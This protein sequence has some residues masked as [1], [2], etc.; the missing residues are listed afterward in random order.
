MTDD[1]H[2]PQIKIIDESTSEIISKSKSRRQFIKSP[3]GLRDNPEFILYGIKTFGADIFQIASQGLRDDHDFVVKAINLSTYVYKYLSKQWREE[4]VGL[5]E[6]K[7]L[8]KLY[9]FLPKRFHD[10]EALLIHTIGY[11][12]RNFQFASVRLKNKYACVMVAIEKHGEVLQY[13]DESFKN[14]KYIVLKAVERGR[15]MLKYASEALRDDRD[16][17]MKAM[18]YDVFN[19]PY[20]SERLRDDYEIAYMAMKDYGRAH[21]KFLSQRLQNDRIMIDMKMNFVFVTM[22]CQ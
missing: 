1:I 7:D 15:E 19:F 22:G 6:Q 16:V 3:T 14:D 21:F 12:A 10:D 9:E 5:L 18:Q 13:L 20:A 4:F 8:W 2:S 17:V 11:S